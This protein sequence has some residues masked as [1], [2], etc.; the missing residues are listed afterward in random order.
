MTWRLVPEAVKWENQSQPEQ[1]NSIST[2]ILLERIHYWSTSSGY[3]SVD[4][5][6]RKKE[7]TMS[8]DLSHT[9]MTHYLHFG[10]RRATWKEDEEL[11]RWR[12]YG[13]VWSAFINHRLSGKHCSRPA[14]DRNWL[15]FFMRNLFYFK[16]AWAS[17]SWHAEEYYSGSREV[18][19]TGTALT[20]SCV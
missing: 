8:I 13:F 20:C 10:L 2:L 3:N 9:W 17:I 6:K 7:K 5:K 1:Q 14:C 12:L 19:V 15:A 18:S 4:L 11:P 16:F